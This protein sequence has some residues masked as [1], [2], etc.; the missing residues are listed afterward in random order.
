MA[1]SVAESPSEGGIPRVFRPFLYLFPKDFRDTSRAQRQ[2]TNQKTLIPALFFSK[3]YGILLGKR[4]P[5]ELRCPSD[6]LHFRT[7][8]PPKKNFLKTFSWGERGVAWRSNLLQSAKRSISSFLNELIIF[9][10]RNAS[11]M[12]IL[13]FQKKATGLR[14]YSTFRTALEHNSSAVRFSLCR[15]APAMLLRL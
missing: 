9:P 6:V 7:H 15:F 10:K 14:Q 12:G 4:S 5:S 2:K 11:L 13:L 1:E 3:L 8:P